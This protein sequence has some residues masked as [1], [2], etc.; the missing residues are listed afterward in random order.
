MKK[1]KAAFFDIREFEKKHIDE[2]TPDYLSLIKINDTFHSAFENKLNEI[3][4]IELLSVFTT[5][6]VSA[7][8]LKKLPN[9]RLILTRS[10]GINH[11]DVDYCKNNNII[12]AN[13]PSYG[14]RTIAEYAIGLLITV[15]RKITH[16]YNS[17]KKGIIDVQAFMGNDLYEKTVGV[18]GTGAIGTH[19]IRIAKGFGMNVI[20]Y[21]PYPKQALIDEHN[22]KYV[23]LDELYSESDIISIHCPAT[24]ENF[25]LISD[26][27]FN[28]MKEGVIIIN[29][30]RGDIMDTEALYKALIAKKVSGAGL[31]VLECEDILTQ[32]SKYFLKMDCIKEDCLKRTLL[33][34]KLLEVENVI[35]TPH[36]AYD[37]IEAINRIIEVTFQNITKFS[38]GDEIKPAF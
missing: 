27:Q 32:E 19:F 15:S 5:S 17:L 37:S 12:I 33:N 26:T 25:H 21:D 18:I 14:E 23:T 13:V 6:T 30:A 36:I 20:A 11:I 2:I 7:E 10:T 16:A 38:N 31:D 3:K 9:L 22:V 28:K 1:I 4:D 8:A 35:I 34:H 29:T 24:K